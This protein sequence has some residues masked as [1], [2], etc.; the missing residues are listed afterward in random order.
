MAG[1]LHVPVA[2]LIFL[3]LAAMAQQPGGLLEFVLLG[4]GW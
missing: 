3:V 4:R 1:A 2:E